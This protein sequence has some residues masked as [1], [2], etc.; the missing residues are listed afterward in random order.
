MESFDGFEAPSLQGAAV[1]NE[2]RNVS[3]FNEDA[4]RL[5]V[6]NGCEDLVVVSTKDA[7]Y[8]SRKGE[9]IICLPHRLV[10]QIESNEESELDAVTY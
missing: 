6:V 10:I 7:A 9:S 2:C 8:I 5:V 4:S 3:V 1:T